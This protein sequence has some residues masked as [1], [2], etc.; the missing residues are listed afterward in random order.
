MTIVVLATSLVGQF[1][2]LV[3]VGQKLK[4]YSN[5]ELPSW[6][7]LDPSSVSLNQKCHVKKDMKKVFGLSATIWT[8]SRKSRELHSLSN[9][10]NLLCYSLNVVV[11]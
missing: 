8:L 6:L 11:D 3:H 5:T 7:H 10:S 2:M 1:D 9:R 4:K